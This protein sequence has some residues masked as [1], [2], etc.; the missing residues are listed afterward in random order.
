MMQCRFTDLHA[1]VSG[2]IPGKVGH[3]DKN[4]FPCGLEDGG[5]ELD[6]NPKSLISTYD[7]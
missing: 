6:V 2:S 3:F 7:V 4:I 1:S 5:T